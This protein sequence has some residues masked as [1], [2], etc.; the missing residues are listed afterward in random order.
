MLCLV[1]PRARKASDG[2]LGS[3]WKGPYII[4]GKLGNEAYH[5]ENMDGA[6]LP[7]AWNEEH[8]R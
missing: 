5:L 6:I 1:F 8:L 7:R 2:T 4:K 3:N